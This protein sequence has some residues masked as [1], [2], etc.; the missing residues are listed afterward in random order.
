MNSLKFDI[1]DK[2]VFSGNGSRVIGFI[3]I[4]EDIIKEYTNLI[5]KYIIKS[6][7]KVDEVIF[8]IKNPKEA[9]CKGG[10]YSSNKYDFES[11]NNKKVVLHSNNTN[12]IIKMEKING[13]TYEAIDDKYK[14]ETVN[15]VY[16]FLSFVF[17]NLK[18]FSTKGFILDHNSIEIGKEVC[19]NENRIRKYLDIG[20][21]S[22][23]KSV[24]KEELLNE[25]LF[26]YPLKGILF[27]LSR[28]I[29]KKQKN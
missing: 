3:S 7:K 4:D 6:E 12:K 5:I 8:N 23:L 11:I 1:P 29:Y 21:S 10:L 18:F 17:N 13:D 24:S 9:T 19:L 14:S 25:S 2:I 28:E 16:E 20:L 22:K 27:D 26:F 15:E